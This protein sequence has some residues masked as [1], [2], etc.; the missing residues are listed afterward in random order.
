MRARERHGA[1]LSR[2]DR[3]APLVAHTWANRCG[4]S[5]GRSRGG[6]ERT[7]ER[8]GA[9]LSRSDRDAPLAAHVWA[10]CQPQPGRAEA[11][12]RVAQS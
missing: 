9:G 3:H 12:G 7:R 4:P 6:L 8:H 11:N 2:R 5:V 10:L 1:C